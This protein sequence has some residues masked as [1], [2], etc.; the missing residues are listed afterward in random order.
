[1]NINKQPAIDWHLALTVTSAFTSEI[2]IWNLDWCVYRQHTWLRKGEVIVLVT[3]LIML[4]FMDLRR[5]KVS[6]LHI[7]K[8]VICDKKFPPPNKYK[9]QISPR[10]PDQYWSDINLTLMCQLANR[11]FMNSGW[12]RPW[13]T[14]SGRPGR[15]EADDSPKTARK[16]V[17]AAAGE[18]K[19]YSC[20]IFK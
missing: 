19:L 3:W 16:E 6:R 5:P 14:F 2:W 17:T 4:G 10:P 12:D 1:M 8:I 15:W 13:I 11:S 18:K 9:N 20:Y 7:V